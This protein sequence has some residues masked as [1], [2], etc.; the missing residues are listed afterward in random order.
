M[1]QPPAETGA[2]FFDPRLDE[3]LE[4]H[5]LL[6]WVTATEDPV[7]ESF[8]DH[9]LDLQAELSAIITDDELVMRVRT[10]TRRRV[11]PLILTAPGLAAIRLFAARILDTH[12]DLQATYAL[13]MVL[14]AIGRLIGDRKGRLNSLEVIGK[15]FAYA[16]AREEERIVAGGMLFDAGGCA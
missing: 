11:D 7:I 15:R 13:D 12:E 16:L 6:G 14:D 8:T 1:V 10:Q 2:P 9:R 4:H 3:A 5:Q